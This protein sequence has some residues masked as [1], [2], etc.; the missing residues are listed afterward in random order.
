MEF[1][2]KATRV[3]DGVTFVI[4]SPERGR[5]GVTIGALEAA[6]TVGIGKGLSGGGG[7]G[8]GRATLQMLKK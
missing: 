4:S 2:V 1:E 6:A 3:A 8:R 5:C 7:R